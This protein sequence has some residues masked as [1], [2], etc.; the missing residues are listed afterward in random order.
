MGDFDGDGKSDFAVY[1]PAEG[2]WYW[3]NS[4]DNSLSVYNFGL[5]EDLPIPSDYNG[6]GKA[7]VSVFRPSN[8]TWYRL[9]ISNF[10]FSARVFG[11]NGDVPSPTSVQPIGQ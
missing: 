3:L 4:K 6:D 7:D 10:T 2:N 1:R 5:A 11:Q 8:N 9:D